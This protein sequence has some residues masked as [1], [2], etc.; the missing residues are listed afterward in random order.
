MSTSHWQ[1]VHNNR[2]IVSNTPEQLWDNAVKY[3]QWCDEHPIIT[4]MPLTS[5]KE[6]GMQIKKEQP[7]QYNIK[8]LCLHC[9]ITEDYITSIRAAR[10]TDSEYYHVVS[11]ILYIIYAQNLEYAVVDV[12]NPILVSKMLNLE[13]EE[14]PQIGT[15]VRVIHEDPT[16]GNRIPELSETENQLLEKLELEISLAEKTKEK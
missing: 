14:T 9:N 1:M 11:K 12:F 6:A 7:R 13:K 3:F 15:T 5:G 2:H 10:D 8:A 4:K 16:T